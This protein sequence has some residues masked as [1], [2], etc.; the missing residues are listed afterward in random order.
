MKKA[1]LKAKMYLKNTG[2]IT[3]DP[4]ADIEK[5][6]IEIAVS[7]DGS[8]GS[9][10]WTSRNGIVDVC[11]EQTGKVLDVT[12]KSAFCRQCS[13]IKEKKNLEMYLTL[14]IQNS[15]LNTNPST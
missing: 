4:L 9:R 7:V 13:K 5:Q 11:I 6:N 14:T 1:A 8:R 10:D 12:I 3:F 15:T 2:S